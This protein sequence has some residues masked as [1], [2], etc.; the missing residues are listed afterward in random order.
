VARPSGSVHVVGRLSPGHPFLGFA[1]ADGGYAPVVGSPDGGWHVVAG[2]DLDRGGRRA[3][4]V[5]L[6]I[7]FFLESLTD[8]PPGLEAT[9]ADVARLVASLEAS[10]GSPADGAVVREALDAIDD[11]LAVDAV[12]IRLQRLLPPDV[13]PPRL[14]ARW[15]AEFSRAPRRAER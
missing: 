15:S 6:A 3:G 10:S 12:V 4:L 2:A 9:H 7:A 14:L 8:P 11:G 5:C 13:D 1:A